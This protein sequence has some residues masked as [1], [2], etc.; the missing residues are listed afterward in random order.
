MLGYSDEYDRY[1]VALAGFDI[2]TQPLFD[3]WTGIGFH[4]GRGL[5]PGAL[6]PR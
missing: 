1:A 3:R 6:A 4:A 2:G 5:R